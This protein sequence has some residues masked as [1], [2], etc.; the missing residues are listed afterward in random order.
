MVMSRFR[1]S[2]KGEIWNHPTDVCKIQGIAKALPST[3]FWIPTRAW[4]CPEMEDHIR[5]YAMCMPNVCVLASVDPCVSEHELDY[6]R[7][8]GWSL[9][10]AGDNERGHM[11]LG[12][13]GAEPN[14]TDGMHSCAKTW[15]QREGHCATC[16]DGCFKVGRKEIHLKQHL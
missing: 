3:R 4:R 7:S 9:V 2:V 5:R 14:L 11:K 15:E 6:L 8:H 16:E 12:P 13:G 10:F 1:F